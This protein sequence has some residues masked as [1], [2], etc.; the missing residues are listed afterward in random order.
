[1]ESGASLRAVRNRKLT[2]VGDHK[3]NTSRTAILL[4]TFETLDMEGKSRKV[5]KEGD[6]VTIT[7][8][9]TISTMDRVLT[10]RANPALYLNGDVRMMPLIA[11]DDGTSAV[12]ITYQAARRID[13][14]KLT[15][16]VEVYV[17]E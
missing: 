9:A 14:S 16:I 4:I 10:I 17:H 8:N 15:H 13:L 11:P 1:M 2:I 12:L 3:M 5:L 6:I 7:T